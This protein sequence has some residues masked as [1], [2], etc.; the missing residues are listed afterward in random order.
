MLRFLTRK[1]IHRCLR[2]LRL[3]AGLSHPFQEFKDLRVAG[4]E[5]QSAPANLHGSIRIA[6]IQCL[7]RLFPHGRHQVLSVCGAVI[8][9]DSISEENKGS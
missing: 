9:L 6:C 5:G 4:V 1:E 3:T 7:G 2:G 8:P